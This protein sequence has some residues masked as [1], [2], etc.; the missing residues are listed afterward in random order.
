MLSVI[1][2]KN[3]FNKT[4]TNS[5]WSEFLRN[6]P[7]NIS[8]LGEKPYKC[9]QC[10]SAF[11]E[12]INLIRHIRLHNG[13]FNRFNWNCSN[14]GDKPYKCEQCPMYFARKSNLTRHILIHKGL[15][16]AKNTFKLF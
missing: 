11:A 2:A 4:C 5:Y 1:C 13:L 15:T 9:D 14:V 10:S 12:K 3:P 7:W 16:S 8:H 6:M